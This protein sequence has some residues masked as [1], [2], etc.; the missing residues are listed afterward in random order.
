ME[1]TTNKQLHQ[2]SSGPDNSTA[3]KNKNVD[4]ALWNACKFGDAEQCKA[5]LEKGANP[6]GCKDTLKS[7]E[8]G[9]RIN[10][11]SSP[12]CAAAHKGFEEIVGIL[13]EHGADVNVRVD[14]LVVNRSA[15]SSFTTTTPR[16]II[17]S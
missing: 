4:G 13:I 16:L 9:Q 8:G 14:S 1:A 2:T 10:Q 11:S 15:L 17:S 7:I 12:L 5:A 6:D 3:F